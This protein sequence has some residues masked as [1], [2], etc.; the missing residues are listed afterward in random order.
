[1]FQDNA[2]QTVR[3]GA[4]IHDDNIGRE[5]DCVNAILAL[6]WVSRRR[7]RETLTGSVEELSFEAA[8][9]GILS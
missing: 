9:S 3:Q 4:V 5:G 8:Q 1:M 2:P 7:I 6:S